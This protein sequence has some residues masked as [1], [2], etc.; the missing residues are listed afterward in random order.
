MEKNQYCRMKSPYSSDEKGVRIRMTVM[1]KK[2]SSEVKK[3]GGRNINNCLP[4]S[5]LFDCRTCQILATP[6]FEVVRRYGLGVEMDF[7]EVPVAESTGEKVTEL[8]LDVP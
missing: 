1:Y 7:E 2:F 6:S 4:C 3:D 8:I 5:L